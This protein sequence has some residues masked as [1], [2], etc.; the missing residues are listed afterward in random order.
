M[1]LEK[2]PITSALQETRSFIF[3]KAVERIPVDGYLRL[4]Y[5]QGKG[6][7]NDEVKQ[8]LAGAEVIK[9]AANRQEKK[10]NIFNREIKFFTDPTVT[11][12][13]TLLK[14]VP[15]SV[16]LPTRVAVLESA[17]TSTRET[18]EYCREWGRFRQEE[19]AIDEEK[20]RVSDLDLT[21]AVIFAAN[22]CLSG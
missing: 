8:I 22:T 4:R 21:N 12:A 5:W 7:P 6:V 17:I 14:R 13:R 15:L 2:A 20:E 11:I 10:Y 16:Y 19:A 1:A 9:E 18:I 3:T